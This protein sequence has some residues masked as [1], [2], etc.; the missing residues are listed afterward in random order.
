MQHV[1]TKKMAA[2]ATLHC[3]IGCAIGELAGLEI[4]RLAGFGMHEVVVLASILSFVSGYAMSTWPLIRAGVPFKKAFKTVL[5]ADTLSIL[6]M[7]VVDNI[8]MM[9]VPGAM[10][11]DPLT[12]TYWSSRAVSFSVAFLV[13]WPVNYWLLKRGQGHALT[14]KYHHAGHADKP[15]HHGHHTHHQAK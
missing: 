8:I 1:A 2:Q 3:L 15:M 9:T 14:H 5:A 11:K 4:G 10:N 7:T 12:W 6:T 13:A